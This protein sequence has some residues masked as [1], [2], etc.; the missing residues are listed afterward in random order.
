MHPMPCA[1]LMQ[2]SEHETNQQAG[3]VVSRSRAACAHDACIPTSAKDS[4]TWS[5]AM[6]LEGPQSDTCVHPQPPALG[7]STPHWPM[8]RRCLHGRVERWPA[9]AQRHSAC[10]RRADPA[11]RAAAQQ[12]VHPPCAATTPLKQAFRTRFQQC[13]L[14]WDQV[15][16]AS[17]TIEPVAD[18]ARG[19]R[20][21]RAGRQRQPAQRAGLQQPR[22]VCAYPRRLARRQAVAGAS[23]GRASRR[24]QQAAH[25]CGGGS[26]ALPPVQ[27]CSHASCGYT[28][29]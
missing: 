5:A 9:H 11:K 28:W 12:R 18:V 10:W 21:A 15:Q 14:G 6:S 7:R 26:P 25:G 8:T 23:H 17:R 1:C 3:G 24:P 16:Q 19:Q 20:A 4:T 2:V 13:M 29:A 22:Q 27:V